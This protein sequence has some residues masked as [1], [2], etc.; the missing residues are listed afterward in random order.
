MIYCI[1]NNNHRINLNCH[2]SYIDS[3][4]WL[5]NKKA[6]I[7]PKNNDDKSFQY[8]VTVASNHEKIVKDPHRISKIKPCNDQYNWKEK[9]FPSHK[10][11]NSFN[12]YRWLKMGLSHHKKIAYII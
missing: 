1:T 6:T 12:D 7:I 4:K 8:A 5:K 11:S 3:P 2:G 9:R 10:K